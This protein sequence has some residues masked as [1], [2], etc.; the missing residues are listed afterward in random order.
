MKDMRRHAEWSD[1]F[2]NYIPAGQAFEEFCERCYTDERDLSVPITKEEIRLL[3]ALM[4]KEAEAFIDA[5]STCPYNG[6]QLVRDY[7]GRV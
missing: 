7:I 6:L 4:T 2:F 5:N 1:A 3:I